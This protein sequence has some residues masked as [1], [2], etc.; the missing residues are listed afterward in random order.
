MATKNEGICGHCLKMVSPIVIEEN[1]FFRD[2]CQC[3]ECKQDLYPCR[4]PTCYDYAKG[5]KGYDHEL[6]PACTKSLAEGAGELMRPVAVA[7]IATATAY[8]V[9]KFNEKE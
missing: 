1:T 2:K 8:V 3:P 7:A 6:C 4:S 9:G 5:T